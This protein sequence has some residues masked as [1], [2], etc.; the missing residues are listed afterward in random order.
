[1]STPGATK[2]RALPKF[3]Q[4]GL[5]FNLSV[6]PTAIAPLAHAGELTPSPSLPADTVTT[7]PCETAQFNFFANWSPSQ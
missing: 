2:S 6:A 3:D 4:P 1:M 7:K 5:T